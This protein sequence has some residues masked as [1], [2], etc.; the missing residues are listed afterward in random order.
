M[1][2]GSA[3]N[4]ASI[5]ARIRWTQRPCKPAFQKS[6]SFVEALAEGRLPSPCPTARFCEAN[7]VT[8]NASVGIGIAGAHTATAVAYGSGRRRNRRHTAYLA[9][10]AA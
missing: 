5:A 6:S 10:E 4:F 9:L 2:C 7:Q 8:E 3:F 1:N